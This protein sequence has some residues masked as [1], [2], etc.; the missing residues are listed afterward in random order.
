MLWF[1]LKP[2]VAAHQQVKSSHRC[3]AR[4]IGRVGN[5]LQTARSLNFEATGQHLTRDRSYWHLRAVL[6]ALGPGAGL[7]QTGLDNIHITHC[8]QN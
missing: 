4:A 1:S 5:D 2:Q 7:D 6:V 3:A 8:G